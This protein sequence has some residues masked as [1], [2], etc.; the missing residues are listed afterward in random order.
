MKKFKLRI[1][2]VLSRRLRNKLLLLWVLLLAA[3]VYDLFQPFLGSLWFILWLVIPVVLVLWI[4]YAFVVPRAW[5]AV[6]PDYLLLRVPFRQVKISYGRV[7]AVTAT[8]LAQHYSLKE[9]NGRERVL[10]KPFFNQTCALIELSS[11]PPAMKRRHL[12]FPRI[13]FS[14]GRPGLLLVVDDWMAL[15]RD[16]TSARDRWRDK[17]APKKGPDDQDGRSLAAKILDY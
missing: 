10:A 13:F 2:D 16:V 4:Y 9:L 5:L 12:W 3:A 17:K 6:T 14:T 7:A 15:S 11:F 1:F 8:Q